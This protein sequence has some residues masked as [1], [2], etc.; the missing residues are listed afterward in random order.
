MIRVVFGICI[1]LSELVDQAIGRDNQQQVK[2]LT[3][4]EILLVI[5][6]VSIIAGTG[7]VTIGP[8][9]RLLGADEEMLPLISQYME[10]W[11][12]G[13]GFVVIAIV[14]QFVDPRYWGISQP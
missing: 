11:Y 5:L 6:M 1:G 13:V 4:D 3:T 14:W 7:L 2:R 8:T 9:F 12:L 10:F